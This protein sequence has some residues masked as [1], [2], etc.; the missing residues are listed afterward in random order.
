MVTSYK[1]NLRR[2]PLWLDVYSEPLCILFT[3]CVLGDVL[4]SLYSVLSKVII[5][6]ARLLFLSIAINVFT[7]L[8]G[9]P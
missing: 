6:L 4:G 9:L 8:L 5:A 3:Q 1:T 2:L 7:G